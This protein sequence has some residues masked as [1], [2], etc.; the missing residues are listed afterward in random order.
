MIE[1]EPMAK[2]VIKNFIQLN[3]P[4][5]KL[6]SPN[7]NTHAYTVTRIQP[8]TQNKNK[9]KVNYFSNRYFQVNNNIYML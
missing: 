3:L 6:I 5:M 2:G 7:L 1:Y 4:D 9:K 8:T